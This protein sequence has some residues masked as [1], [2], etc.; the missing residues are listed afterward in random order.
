MNGTVTLESFG[1]DPI[2]LS[3]VKVLGLFVLLVLI[4][5][6]TIW[7]ERRVVGRMQLRI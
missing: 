4:V 3:I 1:N 7:F 5:L 6:F 2:W